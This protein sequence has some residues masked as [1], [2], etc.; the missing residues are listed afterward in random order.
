MSMGLMFNDQSLAIN[1]AI[2]ILLFAPAAQ[3]VTKVD[4]LNEV[5]ADFAV[6]PNTAPPIVVGATPAE[7]SSVVM[8]ELKFEMPLM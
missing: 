6:R 8:L 7:V 5:A 2:A 3:A 4:K 1:A